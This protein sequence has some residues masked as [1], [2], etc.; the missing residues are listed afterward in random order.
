VARGQ[1]KDSAGYAVL[2]EREVPAGPILRD[3]EIMLL[4]ESNHTDPM[5]LRRTEVWVE[6]KQD[7]LVVLDSSAST[8]TNNSGLRH[9][10][11]P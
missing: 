7:T 4:S 6:D 8:L 5:R 1:L 9:F 11:M 2:S 3:E 10:T